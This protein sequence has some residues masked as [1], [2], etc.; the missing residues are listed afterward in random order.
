[1]NTTIFWIA[2]AAC[3]ILFELGHPG[4][5]VFLGLAAGAVPGIL[6]SFYGYTPVAQMAAVGIASLLFTALA[7]VWARRTEKRRHGNAYASNIYR[8]QGQAGVVVQNIEPHAVGLVKLGGELWSARSVNEQLVE[9]NTMVIVVNVVGCH[10]V[11]QPVR[12]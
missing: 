5:F 4:L 1:M 9:N 7:Y 8:L 3:A 2:W 6:L 12:S 11:V 10:L